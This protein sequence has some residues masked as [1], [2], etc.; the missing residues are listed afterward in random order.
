MAIDYG[1]AIRVNAIAPGYV[2]TPLTE[3]VFDSKEEQD[4]ELGLVADQLAMKRIGRPEDVG[5]AVA[6]LVSDEAA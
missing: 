4:R 6:I 5:L 2:L 1:P 3:S